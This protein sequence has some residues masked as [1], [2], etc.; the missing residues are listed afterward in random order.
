[1]QIQRPFREPFG[2]TRSLSKVSR[3]RD[4]VKYSMEEILDEYL[5]ESKL[6]EKPVAPLFPTTFGK[7]RQ[8]GSRPMTRLDAANLLKR[9]LRDAGI[10][11]DYS[12]LLAN[13]NQIAVPALGW[14]GKHRAVR[15]RSVRSESEFQPDNHRKPLHRTVRKIRRLERV[16]E[17]MCPT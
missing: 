7:S 6:R 12:P 16:A 8:L 10:V 15:E 4:P 2:V 1:V 5:K 9:R 11:G 3:A 14:H 13:A 17:G